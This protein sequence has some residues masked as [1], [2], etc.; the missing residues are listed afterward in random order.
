MVQAVRRGVPLR[1]LADQFG[2]AL[3]T[4]PRW[5]ARAQGQRLDRVD[6]TDRPGGLPT[7]VNR[8]E[9]QREDLV[10]TIR[11]ELRATSALGEFGA[12]ALHREWLARGLPD[13][14]SLRTPGLILQRRGALDRRRRARR[15]PPPAGWY[16]PAVADGRAELD[17]LD[18]VE[19]LV[20]RGGIPVEVL[21][22]ISRHGGLVAAGPHTALTATFV[23]ESLV[24]HWRAV[25]LPGYAPFDN[26][27]IFEGPPIHPDT[28]GRVARACLSRGVVPVFVPP[29][30][31]GFPAAIAG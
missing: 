27:P 12:A 1:Q 30:E 17:S 18:G 9:R 6:W 21:T 29:R 11:Q 22:G 24:E 26:G 20:S 13:P 4:V 14:P 16:L 8:T 19:G 10:L 5:V 25:G 31:T 7:P 3:A 28:V 23:V 15:P 2:V